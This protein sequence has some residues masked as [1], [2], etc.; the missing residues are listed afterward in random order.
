MTKTTF[1]YIIIGGGSAGCVLANRLSADEKHQVCLL[2]AGA[3]DKSPF[4]R[5]PLGIVM[6]MRSKTLNWHFFTR[7]QK[8][9][10]DRPIYWPR[11]RGLGGSSSINAMCYIRGNAHD[12]DNWAALGNQG[13][14]YQEVLPYFIKLENFESGANQLHGV[15]GPLNISASCDLNPL[16]ETFIEAGKQAGYAELPDLNIDNPNGVG[17]FHVTQKNGER[18][19]N[20]RAYLRPVEKRKNLSIITHAHATKILFDDKRAIGVRYMRDGRSFDV[21]ARKEVILSAGAIGSPQLLLLS[22]IGP[23][24][25]IEKHGIKLVHDLPGVGEN[26]Q[27]HLDIHITCLEKTRHALSFHFSSWWLFVVDTFKYIFKRRGCLTSN[28]TQASGFIK[29]DPALP[30]PNIQWHFAP[31][32]Y[33]NSA[34]ELKNMFKYYGYT[35][36]TCLLNP[37]SRGHIRLHSADPMAAPDIDPNY[38]AEK[39]D[40][41][42]MVSGFKKARAVLAQAAFKPY[43]LREFQP[44]EE[45]ETDDQIADYIRQHAETVYHPVGTCKM[46]HD[47]MAVVDP[48]TLKVHGLQNLRVIDASVMPTLTSGNTNAPTTMIAEKGAE[49]ILRDGEAVNRETA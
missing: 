43:F 15:G 25:E 24:A 7:P 45:I 32:V 49:M 9:C 17:Y 5:M 37:S 33:T 11:G 42:A 46:G 3:R 4:I 23:M 1:D 13:W 30:S 2:E 47:A 12:Y 34:R 28:Y 29:T 22:G 31:S 38:L 10:A 14:S 39:S 21:F 40:L 8:Q 48:Q 19:S 44:G 41:D 6:A 26:L 18:Y 20:A 35:L 16:M 36:M 27:D